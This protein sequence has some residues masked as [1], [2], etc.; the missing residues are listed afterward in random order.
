MSAGNN[1]SNDRQ[2]HLTLADAYQHLTGRG[3]HVSDIFN[4]FHADKI[5]SIK[6]HCC[7]FFTVNQRGSLTW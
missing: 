7:L 6:Q 3:Q 5:A 4:V 1:W 2:T